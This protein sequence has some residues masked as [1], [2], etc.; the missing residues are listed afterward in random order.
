[1]GKRRR[2]FGDL[3]GGLAAEQLREGLRNRAARKK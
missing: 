3:P 2:G 1:M